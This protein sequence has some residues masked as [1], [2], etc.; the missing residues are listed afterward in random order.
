MAGSLAQGKACLLS[1]SWV[2]SA[3]YML[4]FYF[5]RKHIQICEKLTTYQSVKHKTIGPQR[6]FMVSNLGP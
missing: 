3:S 1:H 6:A 5:S 4:E 2:S